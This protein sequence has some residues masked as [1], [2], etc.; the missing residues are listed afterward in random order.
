MNFGFR[1][2]YGYSSTEER[3]PSAP[4][5]MT[6]TASD[7]EAGQVTITRSGGTGYPTP[8]YTITRG[9]TELTT[10]ASFPYVDTIGEG[11]YT[12][13]V[14]A[15]N[16]EGTSTDT[17]DGT[18]VVVDIPISAD[19]ISQD[20]AGSCQYPTSGTCIATS[21][22]TIS[23]SNETGAVTYSWSTNNGAVIASGQG[24]N[25]VTVTTDS[26]GDVTFTLN[27]NIDDDNSS[28]SLAVDF[29]HSRSE[30][31]VLA[32]IISLNGDLTEVV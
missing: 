24:T 1:F 7:D 19:S 10:N 15:T 18:S 6:I 30:E 21:A 27:C 13:E 14:V 25:S 8:S 5:A 16:S 17:D 2:G 12:Y 3:V 26:G 31:G 4:T 22:H 20:S 32:L 23:T 28:D 9:V 29:T 11:T